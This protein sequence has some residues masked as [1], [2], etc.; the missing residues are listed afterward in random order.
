MSSIIFLSKT[1]LI[2]LYMWLARVKAALF[3]VVNFVVNF[4][5][6]SRK[7]TVIVSFIATNSD[8]KSDVYAVY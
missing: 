7:L 5:D 6:L 8:A 1:R 4:S 2:P 3:S